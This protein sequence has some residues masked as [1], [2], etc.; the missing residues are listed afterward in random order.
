MENFPNINGYLS[1]RTNYFESFTEFWHVNNNIN[2]R[3]INIL[4][5]NI[6]S[7]SSNFD[8]LTL[9]LENDS[10]NDKIDVIILT[11]TWHNPLNQNVFEIDGYKLFFSTIKRNQNDGIFI[12]VR[13]KYN[14]DFF[15]YDF[16]ETNI[17]KLTFTNVG[18]PII[19]LCLYRSPSTDIN[20][21]NNTVIKLIK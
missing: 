16:I 9:F 21:F 1:Y 19:L 4:C 7:V 10:N 20:I 5:C 12:F 3:Y 11:E 8:E 14:V 18:V 2:N 6:R 17:V 15:E 13:N